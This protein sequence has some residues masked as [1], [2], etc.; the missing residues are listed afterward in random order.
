MV[1]P[2]MCVGKR[3]EAGRPLVR[4]LQGF[5]LNLRGSSAFGEKKDIG[6]A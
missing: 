6:R 5:S 3:Q 1:V 4:L 2:W